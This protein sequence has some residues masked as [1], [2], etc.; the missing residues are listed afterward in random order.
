VTKRLASRCF[1]MRDVHAKRGVSL[2][3]PRWAMSYLR[4]PMT[5]GR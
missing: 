4:G 1:V 5:G 3:Q 2:V